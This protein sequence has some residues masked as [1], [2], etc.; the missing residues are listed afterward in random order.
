MFDL[1][2]HL[3]E[4]EHYKGY[5]FIFNSGTHIWKEE[6]DYPKDYHGLLIKYARE[7][8]NVFSR[9]DAAGYFEWIGSTTPQQTL[10]NVFANTGSK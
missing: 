10:S 4:Q 3:F 9:E 5:S 1:A 2:A 8:Q 6:P 7:H